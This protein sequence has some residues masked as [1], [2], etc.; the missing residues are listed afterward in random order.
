MR[1]RRLWLA[2]A[3]VVGALVFL[4]VEGLGNAT[5]YFKTADEAVAARS[6]LGTRRF[7]IEGVVVDR[8]VHELAR[9]QLGFTIE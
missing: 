4:V 3:V 8:S 6:Q 1:T 9:G 2:G 5:V 7:R